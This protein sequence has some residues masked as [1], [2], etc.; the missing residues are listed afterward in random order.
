MSTTMAYLHDNWGEVYT[1]GVTNGKHT[2]RARFGAH[3]LLEAS[4]PGCCRRLR[5]G[6]VKELL[7]RRPWPHVGALAPATAACAAIT[8]GLASWSSAVSPSKKKSRGLHC[9]I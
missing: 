8:A 5:E 9:G 6:S 1:F 3:D 2:A 7:H 4:F